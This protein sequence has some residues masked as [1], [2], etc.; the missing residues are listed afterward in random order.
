MLILPK[1]APS[2][3]PEGRKFRR[4]ALLCAPEVWNSA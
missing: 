3:V 1:E 4:A 2:A